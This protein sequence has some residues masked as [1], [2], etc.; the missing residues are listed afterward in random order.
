VAWQVDARFA[1][2]VLTV[3]LAPRVVVRVPTRRR[4][5]AWLGHLLKEMGYVV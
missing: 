3:P 1:D 2:Q 5:G 4:G